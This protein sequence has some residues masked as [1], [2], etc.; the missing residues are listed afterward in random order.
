[1][2]IFALCLVRDEVDVI[3]QTLT[4]AAAWSDAVYV[5]DNGSEDGTWEAV[6]ELAAADSRI[7]PDRRD[8]TPY[9]PNLRRVLFD[10]HRAEASNGDWWC[11]L[12]ADEFYI[13]DPR[14][15]LAQVP[16]RFDEVWAASFEYY[17]TEKD[18]DRY[19]RDPT[20]YGD[21]VP[22]EQKLR[23]YLNNWSEPRFFRYESGLVWATDAWPVRLG[24]AYPRRIRLKHFQ[25]RSPPQIEKRIRTRRAAMERG[26]FLHEMLPAWTE[27]VPAF[28]STDFMT[29]DVRNVPE[30]WKDR[31]MDSALLIEDHPD[32]DYVVDEA[33]MPPIPH[34]RSRWLEWLAKPA[35][36]ARRRLLSFRLRTLDA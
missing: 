20:L 27:A 14:A 16:R 33:A 29:S 25:Y 19:T 17:F 24:P 13:D 11:V 21:D 28:R 5:F 7:V 35:R 1:M 36:R 15:F 23:Y 18:V 10:A 32:A 12:D 22:V 26:R 9:S 31:V 2:K 3:K 30:S 6:L 4:A 34:A 8:S